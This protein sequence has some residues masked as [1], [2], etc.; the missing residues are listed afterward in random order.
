MSI[1]A[2]YKEEE[3]SIVNYLR[4]EYIIRKKYKFANTFLKNNPQPPLTINKKMKLMISGLNMGLS[5][6]IIL[7]FKCTTVSQVSIIPS[8][9]QTRLLAVSYMPIIM[10][11]SP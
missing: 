3:E 8:L 6:L 10:M 1:L 11:P 2:K 4:S 7:G 5:T 9:F